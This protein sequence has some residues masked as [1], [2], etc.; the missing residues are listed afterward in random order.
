MKLK[1]IAA[2]LAVAAI[3]MFVPAAHAQSCVSLSL[4]GAIF[5]DPM[6]LTNPLTY[7]TLP[8]EINN[9]CT[10][11]IYYG[12]RTWSGL[13]SAD[14]TW[15]A[16]NGCT[17]IAASSIC[18]GSLT[19]AGDTDDPKICQPANSPTESFCVNTLTLYFCY[20]KPCPGNNESPAPTLTF[21]W[22]LDNPEVEGTVE[23]ASL[24]FSGP[25]GVKTADQNI[26]ISN[27]ASCGA[28]CTGMVTL[29]Q[30]TTPPNIY[31][32][33]DPCSN[34]SIPQNQKCYV[35]VYAIPVTT[36]H[37]SPGPINVPNNLGNNGRSK[38][39]TTIN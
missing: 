33:N 35:S 27:T 31:I 21:Q 36:T 17:T 7:E 38:V 26:I 2:L 15:W 4:M 3:L 19:V 8:V 32:D 6:P 22:T 37:T 10:Q 5:P 18:Y 14:D 12:T 29:G 16:I 1:S 11:P 23:P 28:D 30:I 39:Y 20:I 13:E 9:Q 25:V 34:Q 24:A